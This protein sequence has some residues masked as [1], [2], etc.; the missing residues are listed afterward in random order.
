MGGES[1]FP[2]LFI[3]APMGRFFLKKLFN[4]VAYEKIKLEGGKNVKVYE[5]L[6][7][8]YYDW[9]GSSNPQHSKMSHDGLLKS[10]LVET[11]GV[12]PKRVSARYSDMILVSTVGLCRASTTVPL[13]EQGMVVAGER[14]QIA[15][16]EH[17]TSIN[18]SFNGSIVG[19]ASS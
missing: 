11:S 10:L 15:S 4:G 6:D 2:K 14:I 12:F 19:K 18:H 9:H 3:K 5:N 17:F 1:S 16:E 8:V 7:F 13:D